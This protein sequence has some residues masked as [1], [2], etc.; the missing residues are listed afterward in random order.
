MIESITSGIGALNGGLTLYILVPMLLIAGTYFTIKSGFVQFVHIKEMFSLLVGGR[1]ETK[2]GGISSFQAF[3]MS[4]A[5]RV[6]TGNMAGVALAI[7]AGGP[8]AVFWMWLIALLGSA[9]AFVE[10]TLAQVY[11]KEAGNG[12]FVGGPAYYMEYALKSRGMGIA[13][14]ILITLCFGFVFN[15]VQSDTISLAFNKAFGVDQNIIAGILVALTAAIIFGGVKRIAKFTEAVV[16]IMAIAYI[17]VVFYVVI[18]NIELIPGVFKTIFSS[19]FGFEQVVGGA[20]GAALMQ[21][22]K[23]G[24]FSNEAGMGSAP[25]AAAT[26][27]VSHPAKQGFIQAL[28]V[29]TDT[30][31]ICSAT[32]FLII[33]SGEYSSGASDGI[34][35]TQ[36][37]LVSLVGSW[38]GIF[39]AASILLFAFSSIIGN[40]YYGE[41]NIMFISKKK[42]YLLIYRL[43]VLGMVIFGALASSALVWNLADIFMSLMAILNIY[44]IFKLA[45]IAMKILKDYLKQKREGKDPIFKASDVGIEK[46]TKYWK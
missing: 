18:V 36:D 32:A 46:D 37:A 2:E 35:L 6:G 8:G 13:F 41:S 10:S 44:A 4:T 30:I 45:P 3:C 33:I 5:S 31:L 16:P 28:G 27:T 20:F 40:Y 25:N 43:L 9:S 29:F 17:L 22:I 34:Q 42:R 14:A 21:G 38:G 11:K 26:A 23:R 39:I 24:L 12:T 19:A 1:G 15:A 7:V